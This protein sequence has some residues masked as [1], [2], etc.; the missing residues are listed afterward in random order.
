[1][2][3][4]TNRGWHFG[5][6]FYCCVDISDCKLMYMYAYK[7]LGLS[8]FALI[9]EIYRI[10]TPEQLKQ[11]TTCCNDTKSVLGFCSLVQNTQANH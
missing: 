7:A 9:L 5:F 3:T 8:K 6:F 1:M 4:T 10:Q 2:E 11:N